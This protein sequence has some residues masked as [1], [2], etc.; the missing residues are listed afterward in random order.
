MIPRVVR[1]IH[2][3]RFHKKVRDPSLRIGYPGRLGRSADAGDV[4][5]A[6]RAE[7]AGWIVDRD[8]DATLLL[9]SVGGYEAA[10][11]T[12]LRAVPEHEDVMEHVAV[13]RSALDAYSRPSDFTWVVLSNGSISLAGEF[14]APDA[15]ALRVVVQYNGMLDSESVDDDVALP[16]VTISTFV[17]E[18]RRF[19]DD[20]IAFTQDIM[21]MGLSKDTSD[22]AREVAHDAALAFVRPSGNR[23]RVL[24]VNVNALQH[25]S[26]ENGPLIS[27]RLF[28]VEYRWRDL[29]K[30][31]ARFDGSAPELNG[32]VSA[33]AEVIIDGIQNRQV[34]AAVTSASSKAMPHT[35]GTMIS[36]LRRYH[37]C[38]MQRPKL[39]ENQNFVASMA[40]VGTA[41]MHE[42]KQA[43]LQDAE[44]ASDAEFVASY[45]L[46]AI[47]TDEPPLQSNV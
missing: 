15:N 12:H 11:E 9:A 27:S 41:L 24:L 18:K 20:T 30:E 33:R 37:E 3:N 5:D 2:D 40:F 39:A 46:C 38:L 10:F 8:V 29:R 43:L 6:A 34:V 35:A 4:V 42:M 44:L 45:N 23:S 21:L 25:T 47:Y 13:I 14:V 17:V 16:P 31:Q 22:V 7:E 1:Q 19:D 26:D 28:D 32:K 36:R